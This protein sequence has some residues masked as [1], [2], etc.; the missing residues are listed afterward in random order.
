MAAAR[1][2]IPVIG[3]D[4]GSRWTAAVLRRGEHAVNGWT[5]GPVD[6]HGM[7][8]PRALDDLDATALAR[9]IARLGVH[10]DG[11]YDQAERYGPPL[12]AV[13]IPG[14]PRGTARVPVRDWLITYSVAWSVVG[15]FDGVRLVRPDR[16]GV[17]H[18]AGEPDRSRLRRTYPPNLVHR[19]PRIWGPCEAPNR[20][21]D[22]ER[23]AFDIAGAALE[24]LRADGPLWIPA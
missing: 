14:P 18:L 16:H 24:R 11:L 2:L 6:E 23:A 7:R 22:H 13:E 1:E 17:R 19:R 9:Y 5:I 8:D 3:V 21:R 12:V 10:L 4:P 15:R 20:R